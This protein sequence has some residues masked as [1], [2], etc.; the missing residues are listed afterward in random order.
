M[1]DN[2]YID[3]YSHTPQQVQWKP[4]PRKAAT[5]LHAT[6]GRNANNSV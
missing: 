1:V 6:A 4:Q 3:K 5:T 2:K